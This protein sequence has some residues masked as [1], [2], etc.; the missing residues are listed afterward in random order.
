MEE[1]LFQM[2]LNGPWSNTACIGYAAIAMK[3]AGMKKKEIEKVC[4]H[5]IWCFDE[6]SVK[7]AEKFW[8]G[9]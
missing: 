2:C 7:E 5:L 4:Q 6:I 8:Q 9:H 3:R 1:E